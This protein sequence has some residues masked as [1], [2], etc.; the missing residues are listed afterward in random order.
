MAIISLG[1]YVPP[2][3]ERGREGGREGGRE[4]I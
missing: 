4:S 1:L 2:L 3:G